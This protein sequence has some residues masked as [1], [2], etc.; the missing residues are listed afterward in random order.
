MS[1][2]GTM[3]AMIAGADGAGLTPN[4]HAIGDLAVDTL[5]D[6][7]A[8]TI[9]ANGDRDRRFRVI[10][11]QVVESDDFARF[12]ELEIVAEV[13]PYHAID[14]MRWMEDRIGDRRVLQVRVPLLDRDLA[15]DQRRAP[16]VAI[17]EDL[18]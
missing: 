2:P 14:D 9:R 18:E 7:F 5:L 4:V 13:Q 3:E 6:F 1:P 17:I 16:V 8:A 12:G 11:A 15:G 10:H